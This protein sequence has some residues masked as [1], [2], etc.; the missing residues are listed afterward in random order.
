MIVLS[1]SLSVLLPRA[2]SLRR[3][4]RLSYLVL[5][6]F[7]AS[8]LLL[9]FLVLLPMFGSIGSLAANILAW[10]VLVDTPI[11]CHIAGDLLLLIRH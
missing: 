2:C 9:V 11:R 7:V 5:I 3:A 8:L 6:S 4:S 1:I 10:N